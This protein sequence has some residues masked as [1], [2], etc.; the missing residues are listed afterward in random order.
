[1]ADRDLFFEFAT[2]DDIDRELALLAKAWK[3][4]GSL[5]K[6]VVRVL[7][8]LASHLAGHTGGKLAIGCHPAR[9]QNQA[10]T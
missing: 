2:Y 10:R 5:T 3:M 6:V 8:E 7:I 9:Y 4:H 1:M